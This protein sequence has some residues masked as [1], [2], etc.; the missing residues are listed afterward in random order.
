MYKAVKNVDIVTPYGIIWDGVILIENDEIKDFG[1]DLEI[2]ENAEIIDGEG[3]YAGPGLVD[4]HVHGGDGVNTYVEPEKAASFF[5]KHGATT[6]LATPSYGL[7]KDGFIKAVKNVK[8]K[9]SEAPTI[10]GLYMEGPYTNPKYG[11]HADL[12]PWRHGVHP[13]DYIPIVDE[14]GTLVK[15]WTVAPEL[16][17]IDGFIKYAKKVNP[18]VVIALGHSEATPEQVR[19][20]G[21]NKPTLM[22]HTTNATGRVN[23]S[24]GIRGCG[25]DEYCFKERD[26]YAELISDSCAIHVKPD[27]QQQ[28]L[29]TK[30]IDRVVL[31]TDSTA[32]NNP[33][34][35]SFSHI[36]DL[37]FDHNGGLAGSKMTMDMA[38]RNIMAS[39]NCGIAQ[40]FI[41]ASLNP[42]KVIGMDKEI[43][44]VEK[45]KKADI[46]FVDDKFNVKK[47]MLRGEIVC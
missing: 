36:T 42:A 47:V 26:M 32:Y 38:C 45:G 6:I 33:N 8:E 10:R 44:S 9:L 15:V 16:E 39:T 18:D 41:M 17:G 20:L 28:I 19:E 3:A 37:N 1:K 35:P 25:P 21:A 4:I 27:M 34:P 24:G 14:A 46:I 43:G 29:H 7:N 30:G 12:N 40:A 5:L 11:S 13:E 23:E 2:P 31:I 22:T